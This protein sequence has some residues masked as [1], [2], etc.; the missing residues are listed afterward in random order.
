MISMYQTDID[1]LLKMSLEQQTSYL[2][3]YSRSSLE[4]R[5]EI[6]KNKHSLFHQFR[7]KNN[8]VDKGLLEYCAL[9]KAISDQYIDEI[10]LSKKSFPGLTQEEI[11]QKSNKKASLFLLTT[12]NEAKQR[13]KVLS[14]WADI[15]NAKLEHRMSFRQIVQ[16]L[17][18]KHRFEVS[19]SLIHNMWAEIEENNTRND[20]DR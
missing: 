3:F 5:I 14:Y 6:L 12:K 20:N 10:S 7:S 2:R 8:E 15:C 19:K 18:K 1:R 11:R 13:Q 4:I 16:F 9:I 17:K